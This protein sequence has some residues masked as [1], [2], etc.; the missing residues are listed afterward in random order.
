MCSLSNLS[1]CLSISFPLLSVYLF[2]FLHHLWSSFHRQIHRKCYLPMYLSRFRTPF[3][4]SIL[5]RTMSLYGVSLSLMVSLDFHKRCCHLFYLRLHLDYL[6]CWLTFLRFWLFNYTIYYTVLTLI[7][8]IFLT[9]FFTLHQYLI[10]AKCLYW[11]MKCPSVIVSIFYFVSSWNVNCDFDCIFVWETHSLLFTE[12]Y[13]CIRVFIVHWNFQNS[14]TNNGR[15]SSLVHSSFP[16]IL[17]S[18]IYFQ[19]LS[20]IPTFIRI[21][22]KVLFILSSHSC[23]SLLGIRAVTTWSGK[24]EATNRQDMNVHVI[25]FACCIDWRY[26]TCQCC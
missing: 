21:P 23:L 2:C 10:F 6:W 25:C 22:G 13:C 9:D 5:Y 7:I 15:D 17:A 14:H 8:I 12:F 26:Y 19:R 16:S 18:K 20:D 4:S 24:H 11:N 1:L 3:L